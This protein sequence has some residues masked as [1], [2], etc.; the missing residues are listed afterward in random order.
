MGRIRSADLPTVTSTLNMM[1]SWKPSVPWDQAEEDGNLS[2]V[3]G[4]L[5]GFLMTF[6]VA[7]TVTP[8]D[9]HT[10]TVEAL[11]AFTE[12]LGRLALYPKDPY[13]SAIREL[14]VEERSD[15]DSLCSPDPD[16]EWQREEY[17]IAQR[18][19]YTP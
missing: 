8:H 3:A 10:S 13:R 17:E 4:H 16:S 12:R 5:H 14:S 1:T 7:L 18:E 9:E 6:E 11:E 19:F 2:R 15:T